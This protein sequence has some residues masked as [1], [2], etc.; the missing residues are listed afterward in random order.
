MPP[1]K[2]LDF[3]AIAGEC[4]HEPQVKVNAVATKARSFVLLERKTILF[5]ILRM[6]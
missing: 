5:A 2:L 3:A 1:G 6:R 4:F